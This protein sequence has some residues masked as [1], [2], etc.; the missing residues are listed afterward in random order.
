[1][2]RI[3]GLD[4]LMPIERLGRVESTQRVARQWVLEGRLGD[5]A[6]IFCAAEQTGGIGRFG[7]AWQSPVGGLWCTVA[8]PIDLAMERVRAGLGLRVGLGVMRAI[9]HALGAEGRAGRLKFK[10]PNDVLI[11][12][13]KVAGVL[14]EIIEREGK[15]FALVGVGVNGNFSVA[16]LPDEIAA[17]ST[18]LSDEMGHEA[19]MAGLLD[20][21]RASMVDAL[22]TEGLPAKMLTQLREHLYGVGQ[23][24]AI[25]LPDGSR[26]HGELVGL[27]DDGGLRLV[28]RE[29][30]FLVPLG[31]EV[32][33]G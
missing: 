15:W 26:R 6:R 8:W 33:P 22:T 19:N 28:T 7:R 12:G 27:D 23:Q 9:E 3:Y 21:V 30:E 31:A 13:K 10:W 14:C 17:L 5:G 4:V 25:T 18:T 29:G 24:Q 1:M 11:G 16:A 20:D 32:M 2:R